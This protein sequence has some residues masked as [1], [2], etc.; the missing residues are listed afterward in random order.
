MATAK[1]SRKNKHFST[2]EYTVTKVDPTLRH[3]EAV[4]VIGS[5]D[6]LAKQMQFEDEGYFAIVYNVTLKD[7]E[8]RTPGCEK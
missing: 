7:E 2:H 4:T 6:A 5:R 1:R 8:Y 3:I